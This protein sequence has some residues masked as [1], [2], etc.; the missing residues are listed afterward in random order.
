MSTIK[1]QKLGAKIGNSFQVNLVHL[2]GKLQTAKALM[3]VTAQRVAA[4]DG[5][6]LGVSAEAIL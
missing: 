2:L 3:K 5:E 4:N 1:E 6:R